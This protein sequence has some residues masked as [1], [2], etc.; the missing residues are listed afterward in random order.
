[1]SHIFTSIKSFMEL[2]LSLASSVGEMRTE[3]NYLW[4]HKCC[5]IWIALSADLINLGEEEKSSIYCSRRKVFI[6]C[7]F[8]HL[9]MG[10]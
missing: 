2:T 9:L 3:V 6:F 5:F 10:P 7:L 8:K 4:T 1:M